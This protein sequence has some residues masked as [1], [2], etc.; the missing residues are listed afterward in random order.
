MQD[1]A[2]YGPWAA[3]GPPENFIQPTGAHEL[4]VPPLAFLPTRVGGTYLCLYL[5]LDIDI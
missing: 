5:Y 2:K 1:Q 3:S 4:I